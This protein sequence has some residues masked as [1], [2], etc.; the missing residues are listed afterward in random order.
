MTSPSWTKASFYQA[1]GDSLQCTLCPFACEL[2]DGDTGR[3]QVRRRRGDALETATRSS[4][5]FHVNAIERKPFYHV[6][7]GK[8]VLT[9]AAPGCTFACTYCQ[10]FT[11]SQFGRQ[12][13][14]PWSA[15]PVL[16]GE[17][18]QAARKQQALIAF[19]YA[20]PILSAELCMEIAEI[21]HEAGV[22]CVW[23]TNAFITKTSA[24]QL[25]GSIL[26]ANVDLK[27]AE[28]RPHQAL[29]K[30]SLAPVLDTLSI[31]RAEG[32]WLEISTPLIPDVNDDAP[33]IR[34]MA[35]IIRALGPE[36]PWHL[37]RFHPDY[38]LLQKD[39]THPEKLRAARAIARDEGLQY[40]YVERALG[41][42]GR[43]TACPSCHAI[44]IQRDIWSLAANRLEQDKCPCCGI[45]IAGIFMQ[46]A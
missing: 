12:E 46:E 5:V 19:S 8:K 36:V 11:L 21:G 15:K 22:A 42:E 16:A 25:A 44:V 43:Q 9:L 23:K 30:A 35:R 7:P 28:E 40:V 18:V 2:A 33:S 14:A 17:L 4:A 27:A 31:W 6:F 10:N 1:N 37:V 3:C 29:T 41:E 26:A 45:A 24:K 32:V 39:P 34:K 13:E 20:E 38:R